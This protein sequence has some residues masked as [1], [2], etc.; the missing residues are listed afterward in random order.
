LLPGRPQCGRRDGTTVAAAATWQSAP[1][2]RSAW[3]KEQ[4]IA[5]TYLDEW[6][7]DE[8]LDHLR[9][10][11]ALHDPQGSVAERIG[12]LENTASA[13]RGAGRPREALQVFRTCSR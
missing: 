5:I 7:F 10:A 6:R 3:Q 9:T 13:L 2:A 4:G 1:S 11:A 12:L 8:A